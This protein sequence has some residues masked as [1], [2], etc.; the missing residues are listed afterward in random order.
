[1]S[2]EDT[3]FDYCA[4]CGADHGY[5]CGPCDECGSKVFRHNLTPYLKA[6]RLVKKMP[7]GQLAQVWEAI[8]NGGLR[9][10]EE[11]NGISPGDWAEL[12][13]SELST[14]RRLAI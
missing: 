1:M 4:R 12:V 10:A 14:V 6:V 11:V 3:L 13:Y 9:D 2:F 7:D 5:M 8:C